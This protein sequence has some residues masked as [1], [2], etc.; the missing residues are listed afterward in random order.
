M[1]FLIKDIT[2]R[3]GETRT[4][5]KYSNRIGSVIEFSNAVKIGEPAYFKYITYNDGTNADN[6]ETQISR[7]DDIEWYEDKF[8]IYT[9]NSIYKL[10]PIEDTISEEAGEKS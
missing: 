4:E 9:R 7:V 10:V 3:T 2:R 6:H 8:Y 1:K 5:T